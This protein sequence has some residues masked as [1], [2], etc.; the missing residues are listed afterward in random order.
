MARRPRSPWCC[1][2]TSRLMRGRPARL[3][4]ARPRRHGARR[5]FSHTVPVRGLGTREFHLAAPGLM[6]GRP[7]TLHQ[8]PLRLGGCRLATNPVPLAKNPRPDPGLEVQTTAAKIALAQTVLMRLPTFF[9]ASIDRDCSPSSVNH[10]S[11]ALRIACNTARPGS[12][13][14]YRSE[15]WPSLKILQ[16]HLRVENKPRWPGPPPP[17]GSVRHWPGT[18][19]RRS[20]ACSG[21][22]PMRFRPVSAPSPKQY[23][24]G[25]IQITPASPDKPQTG[26]RE[27]RARS[28]KDTVL[29]AVRR[30]CYPIAR[31]LVHDSPRPEC[32]NSLRIADM[33][34]ATEEASE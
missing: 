21:C 25:F 28:R 18:A 1:T 10:S 32:L 7:G 34:A 3:H 8:P 2:S 14:W 12:G 29:P 16:T 6:A 30:A 23:G 17:K 20:G 5:Q 4:P 33:E 15:V 26:S 24:H 27:C 31:P 19:P 9:F 13:Y 11:R 22:P